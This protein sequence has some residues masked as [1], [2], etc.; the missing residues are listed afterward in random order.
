[1]QK[2]DTEK[3]HSVSFGAFRMPQGFFNN[4]VKLYPQEKLFA[5]PM[6]QDG[7]MVSYPADLEQAM[8][9]TCESLLLEH[10]HD[11]Q[12]FPCTG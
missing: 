7:G 3:I 5:G 1:M 8:R 12:L 11:R 2:L 9:S 10:L 4:M 6:E